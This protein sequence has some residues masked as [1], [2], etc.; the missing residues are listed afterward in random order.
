MSTFEQREATRLRV[1]E[2]RRKHAQ[3]LRVER[4]RTV[5]ISDRTGRKP[6]YTCVE[7]VDGAGLPARV[8]AC[9]VDDIP[10]PPA[11]V[12]ESGRWLPPGPMSKRLAETFVRFR[13]D[14]IRGWAGCDAATLAGPGDK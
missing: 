6:L 4:L 14:Q 10:Q 7:W 12:T 11:G 2:H 1:R 3:R 8:F 5:G 9:R 13:L